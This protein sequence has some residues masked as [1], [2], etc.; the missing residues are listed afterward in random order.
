MIF[1]HWRPFGYFYYDNNLIEGNIFMKLKPIIDIWNQGWMLNDCD[2]TNWRQFCQ[3]LLYNYWCLFLCNCILSSNSKV[4][5]ESS[6]K[7]GSSHILIRDTYEF[8]SI[9]I[10]AP[11]RRWYAQQ[12]WYV[13]RSSNHNLS[14]IAEENLWIDYDS[15]IQQQER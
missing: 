13:I 4:T 2:V 15:S 5:Y 8:I 6:L 10:T 11:L 14:L 12:L 7:L 1:I 9:Q 3:W